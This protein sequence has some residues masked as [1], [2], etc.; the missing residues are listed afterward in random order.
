MLALALILYALALAALRE[1]CR[2]DDWQRETWRP[3]QEVGEIASAPPD[4]SAEARR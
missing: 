4:T 3:Y 2:P 1:A